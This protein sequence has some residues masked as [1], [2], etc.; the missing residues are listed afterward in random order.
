MP[1]MMTLLTF[2]AILTVAPQDASSHPPVRITGQEK[3]VRAPSYFEPGQP[4]VSTVR[5]S[6]KCGVEAFQLTFGSASANRVEQF[7]F[8]NRSLTPRQTDVLNGWL[9]SLRG[10]LEV[11]TLCNASGVEVIA[12]E[13]FNQDGG[14]RRWVDFNYLDGELNLVEQ[15]S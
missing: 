7:R 15:K 2:T 11:R 10:Q 8:G 1:L 3:V 13:A 9:S 4:S 14:I 12:T 6:A 5:V